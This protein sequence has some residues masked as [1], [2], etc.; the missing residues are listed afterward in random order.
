MTHETVRIDDNPQP[1]RLLPLAG[2]AGEVY[3]G[4]QKAVLDH[5]LRPGMKLSE[6]EVGAVYGVSRTIV[7]A[8]LQAL[9]FEGIA[10]ILPNRGAFVAKPSIETAGEVFEARA[11]IE[12]E[13]AA[14]AALRMSQDDLEELR[15]HIRQEHEALEN[16][17]QSE[18]IALSGAFHIRIAEL[19]G[20]SVMTGFVRELVSQS[21]LIIALYWKRRETT[22]ES[23]D[24]AD[25]M[26]A[27]SDRDAGHARE[28]MR[29]HIERLQGG[30]D[31]SEQGETP[32]SLSEVLGSVRT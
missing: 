15:R 19:S 12:S 26:Q 8:A 17:N 2:R 13:L 22:C 23:D 3:A 27:F 10:E 28:V 5:R 25:L 18:A 32:V 30:L 4:L 20:Q 7:R 21:S 16:D 9:A 6:D 1:G 11:L 31:L 24:H 29:S 14:K